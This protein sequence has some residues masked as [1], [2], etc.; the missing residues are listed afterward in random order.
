MG[1]VLDDGEYVEPEFVARE[2]IAFAERPAVFKRLEAIRE[3]R[4]RMPRK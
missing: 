1:T 4:P 2:L 3:I